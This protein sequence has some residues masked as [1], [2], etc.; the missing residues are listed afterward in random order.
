M[1]LRLRLIVAF[2]LLSVVPLGAVT[3]YAYTSNARALRDAA[4]READLL[5]GE[6]G[7]RMQLVTAQLTERVEHV[8]D[9]AELQQAVDRA[10]AEAV[11]DQMSAHDALG[12]HARD[13]LGF[14]ETTAARPLQAALTSALTFTVGAAA[15][16]AV[17]PLASKD[18][19]VPAVAV[20]SLLCL[21]LLGALGARTGGARLEPSILRVTSWGVLAMAVTAGV[22]RLFGTAVG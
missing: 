3:F 13:E 20:V 2:F 8:M 6:L 15:P 14:S 22:G 21:A 19:L 9:L 11:A 10:T 7:Q 4:E 1:S 18:A 16:L 12:T 17:V 5:T